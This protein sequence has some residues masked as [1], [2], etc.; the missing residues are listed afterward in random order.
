M[1]ARTDERP[2]LAVRSMQ[3][4]GT[5][6]T[7]VVDAPD[8]PEAADAALVLLALD[9][10]A[11][12]RACSRFRPDSELRR[13]EQRGGRPTLVSP[14]LFAVLEQAYDVAIRTGGIVD[15]T[16]GSAMVEL[17]YD[18]DFALLDEENDLPDLPPTPAPGW[19]RIGLDRSA[20]TVSVP[21]G[22]HVDVGSTGKAFAADQ[23][24]ARIFGALGCSALVNLGGDV[25][26]A[27][28]PP[29]DGWGVGIADHCTTA[30]VDADEVVALRYGG[31]ATSGTTARTWSHA[32]RTVH[33]I[34]D[35]WTGEVA[36]TTWTLVS[37][38]GATCV[39]A[40]GWS[41][42]AVVWGED[43]PGNLIGHGVTA[44]LV[45]ADGDVVTVGDWPG[46]P[47]FASFN[48]SAR[49]DATDR[50]VR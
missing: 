42:A 34:V 38:L 14:L 37:A 50:E 19:W 26:T 3:A 35:P 33:H 23:A 9:L 29:A 49:A 20:R 43:A 16:I 39:E 6:A 2:A 5:T 4:I 32:G 41:T 40:N 36:P 10:D 48:E 45:H 13:L 25:A 47:N 11:L 22:I 21:D 46:V 7:V 12:D 18:R 27:G 24:A 15:P 44:R 1:S 30:P 8:A 31:L 17:G 28:P